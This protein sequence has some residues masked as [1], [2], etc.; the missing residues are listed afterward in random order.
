MN[1][2][3]S[4]TS[5]LVLICDN[6]KS[7]KNLKTQKFLSQLDL[8]KGQKMYNK[9]IHLKPHLDEVIPNRKFF[10]HKYIRQIL[11][12]SVQPVQVLTL[13]CGWDP[14]LLELSEEFPEH[15]FFGVDNESIELQEK[16]IQDIS[17]QANIFYIRADITCEKD[18]LEKL[19]KKSWDI[20]KNT[21]F[22]LEGISYYIAPEAFWRSVG[23]LKQKTEGKVFICGDFLVNKKKQKISELSQQLGR[24]IFEMIKT[25]CS[26]NYYSYTTEEIR[27]KL[28]NLGFLEIQITTQDQ[29]QKERTGSKQPWQEQEGHIQLFCSQSVYKSK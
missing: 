9:I 18:L 28:E 11:R 19:I 26:Q 16:L 22:I 4:Q 24:D 14:I 8:S 15:L 12:K 17:P 1:V 21:C 25:S 23:F 2:P 5:S 3:L 27:R 13:A 29:I 6:N 20:N 7:Y 10:I